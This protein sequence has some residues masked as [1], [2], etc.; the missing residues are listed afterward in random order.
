MNDPGSRVRRLPPLPP[1]AGTEPEQGGMNTGLSEKQ[2]VIFRFGNSGYDALIC[3]GAIRTGKSSLMT[4]AFVDWAMERFDRTRFGICGK[5]ADGCVKNLILPFLG[6]ARTRKK[7]GIR[8]CPSRKEMVVSRRGRRNTFEIFGGLNESS[9]AL[10][11]GRT[12]GGVLLDETVLM[13]RSFTEQAIARC[14]L[15]GSKLW[16]NCNPGSPSHWFY[17]EWILRPEAHNALLLHFTLRDN[18]GLTEDVI[19]RY[20]ASWSGVFRRRYILGEWCAAEGLVYDFGEENLTDEIPE[21]GDVYV[22]VDY[23]TMNPFSAGVWRV[24]RDPAAPGGRRAVRI[25]EYYHDGRKTGIPLT[26]EDYCRE[27]LSLTEGLSVRRVVADPSAASFIAA[28]RRHGFTVIRARND[29]ADGIRLTAGY[30]KT[31]V[32]RIHRSCFDAIREFG[33]YRW[34]EDGGN[35][36]DTVIKENDHAMDDIRYFAATVLRGAGSRETG[37]KTGR[38]GRKTEH[39]LNRETV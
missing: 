25:R 24:F 38:G 23:G 1:I 7:Y 8:W 6:A 33:L 12:F 15:P 5:T 28:L 4:A 19:R 30:L 3:D 22:S 20:E 32:I 36:R 11:Q 29:V 2:K 27:I 16:F 34:A 21:E 10:I 31:G 18:P 17:R 13:P 35:G 39:Y 14:S 9:F 26:D 37:K